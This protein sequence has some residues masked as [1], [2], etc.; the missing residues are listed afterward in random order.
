MQSSLWNRITA[1][2]I[3]VRS[4]TNLYTIYPCSISIN[5]CTH[6]EP[7]LECIKMF[8]LL[9]SQFNY[10]LK[11]EEAGTFYREVCRN[12]NLIPAISCFIKICFRSLS[13]TIKFIIPGLL[14][15]SHFLLLGGG[16][17]FSK[18]FNSLIQVGLFIAHFLKSLTTKPG[19]NWRPTLTCINNSYRNIEFF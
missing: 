3:T 12:L 8:N 13:S 1:W 7:C 19:S 10:F 18:I 2:R 14:I 6:P 17:A 15:F 5:N 9:S 11:P 16:T 4:F